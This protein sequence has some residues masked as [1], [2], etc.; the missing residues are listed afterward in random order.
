[1]KLNNIQIALIA[2]L[3]VGLLTIP[4]I[5]NLPLPEAIKSF[6]TF[7]VAIS[8]GLLTLIGYLVAE[9]LSKWV[10]IFKELGRFAVVGVLNTVLDFAIFNL[11]ISSFAISEG[12]LAS[13]FKG[14]S[15]IVAVINSYYW[16]KYWTFDSHKVVKGKEFIQ[17]IIISLVGFGINV[18][19]FSLVA[20]LIGAPENIDPTTWANIGAL[21]G[22]F[23]GL[24]WNFIGYKLVVFKK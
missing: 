5:N 15:F 22:T 12:P 8:L 13:L 10:A 7:K 11:L 17:F 6:G 4:T 18:G 20:N 9:V 3:L 16:N 23:A 19:T 2:S 1:M 24:A 21:V 14:V